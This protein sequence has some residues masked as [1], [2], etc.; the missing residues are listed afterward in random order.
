MSESGGVSPDG[1][2]CP[3]AGPEGNT[4]TKSVSGVQAAN[5]ELTRA[6]LLQSNLKYNHVTEDMSRSSP[7][8]VPQLQ[9]EPRNTCGTD[10]D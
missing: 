10:K 4:G 3:E 2:P 6:V 9:K 1:H 8:T 5:S 7:N